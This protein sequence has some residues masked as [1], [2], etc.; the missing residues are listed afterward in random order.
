[1][2]KQRRPKIGGFLD[3]L[4]NARIWIPA[5]IPGLGPSGFNWSDDG[6][7]WPKATC[8]PRRRMSGVGARPENISSV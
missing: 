8:E 7:Y 5:G 4:I 6:R 1:M 3:Q 2:S